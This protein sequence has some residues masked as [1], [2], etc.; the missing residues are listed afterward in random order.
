[1]NQQGCLVVVPLLLLGE[2]FAIALPGVDCQVGRAEDEQWPLPPEEA[3]RRLAIS[4]FLSH[5]VTDT[6]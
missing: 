2:G 4:S 5:G 6:T 3:A 1:M